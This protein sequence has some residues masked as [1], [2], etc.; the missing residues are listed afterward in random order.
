MRI[1]KDEILLILRAYREHPTRWTDV[2]D[3]VRQNNDPLRAAA[4]ELYIT[5][6]V[7]QLRDRMSMKLSKLMAARQVIED[8]DKR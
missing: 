6:S 8:E 7:K 4:Q 1:S 5:G 3:D 2:I